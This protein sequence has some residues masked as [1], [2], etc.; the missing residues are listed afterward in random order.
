MQFSSYLLIP[1]CTEGNGTGHL[2][3]MIDFYTI[4]KNVISVSLFIPEEIPKLQMELL[5]SGVDSSDILYDLIPGSF[6]WDCVIF[7]N[8]STSKEQ[9][10]I[11]K[12]RC[13][14]LGIDEGGP[15]RDYFDFLIDIIP[16]PG[17]NIKPNIS[18][19]G[20]LNLPEKCAFKK[21][22]S[23]EKILISFG[24]EDSLSL[25]NIFLDFI[26]KNKYFQSSEITVTG[27]R[28][29]E[30]DSSKG[31][32][33]V[34]I[35][36][37]D[38]KSELKNYNFIITS[39]GLTAFESLASGVPF[40]LLNPSFY[41]HQLSVD[42]GFYEIGIKKPLSARMDKFINKGINF[43][44]LQ[45]KYIPNT[46]TD[47]KDI[48]LSIEKRK[49]KCPVC[50]FNC[51][52]TNLAFRLETRNFYNCPQCK[53]LFQV[54]YKPDFN[55]Y[56]KEYFFEEYKNQYGRTYLEDFNNIRKLS[57]P[58]LKVI[59]SIKPAVSN[60]LLL[61][62]GCAYGP[63]LVESSAF[64]YS[65]TG[66]ELISDAVN[67]IKSELGFPVFSGSFEDIEI[68]ENFDIITMWY[69]IEHFNDPGLIL[70]KIN[71][72]LKIGGIFAFSTPNNRGISG[73]NN[74]RIFL[75]NSPL[76]HITIWNP[77]TAAVVL[78]RFG[79]KIKRIRI[80]GH[81]SERIK[82]FSKIKSKTVHRIL[83]F[84]SRFFSLGD[85]FEVYAEKI[86]EIDV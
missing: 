22:V 83:N 59:S 60:P 51:E 67:Y 48:I 3:R 11:F 16:S 14:L 27:N 81:H 37:K 64:G 25:T 5:S 21:F 79:F 52:S 72:L 45:D 71:N 33:K 15:Y 66:I 2:R 1:A 82:G 56:R 23:F 61:D 68:D 86:K 84:C 42:C 19:T 65:P 50:F 75:S 57:G 76:D 39:F 44:A 4:I 55:S 49:S 18:S 29:L 54:N 28:N 34:L 38:L 17:S 24:G 47:L 35:N 63:F 73:K 41:H 78:K 46:Q 53:I 85:T 13:F 62:V 12:N 77:K 32:V 6:V 58:R 70:S 20:L 9:I 31:K 7:D 36:H 69:V 43:S 80:T 26:N 40:V 10:L 30:F 74:M 8:R